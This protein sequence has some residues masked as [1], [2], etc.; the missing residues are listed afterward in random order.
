M[1]QTFRPAEPFD[2]KIEETPSGSSAPE[3]LGD[4]RRVVVTE[5]RGEPVTL[6]PEFE[7]F[8]P[9]GWTGPWEMQRGTGKPS[10]VVAA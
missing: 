2:E 1:T 4:Q 5:G 6:G 9:A 7:A 3:G 8:F 10:V